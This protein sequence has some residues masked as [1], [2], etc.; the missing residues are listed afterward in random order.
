MEKK[1]KP[2]IPVEA[3]KEAAM[4]AAHLTANTYLS[5]K[6]KDETYECYL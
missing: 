5:S 4:E 1:E 3:G 2:T 6:D